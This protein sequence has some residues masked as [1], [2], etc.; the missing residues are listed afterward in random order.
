MLFTH[1]A[2]NPWTSTVRPSPV[3]PSRET[4]HRPGSPRLRLVY[5]SSWPRRLA[6]NFL[7]AATSARAQPASKHADL[8][9]WRGLVSFCLKCNAGWRAPRLRG[10]QAMEVPTAS[11]PRAEPAWRVQRAAAC[12]WPRV[13]RSPRWP[14]RA[15]IRRRPGQPQAGTTV[16]AGFCPGGDQVGKGLGLRHGIGRG[17]PAPVSTHLPLL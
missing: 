12:S 8:R 10:D 1:S 16:A 9:I 14:R 11:R 2:N 13:T 6:V 17:L 3:L 4:H 7:K 5:G 15:G